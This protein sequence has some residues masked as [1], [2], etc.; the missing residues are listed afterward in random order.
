MGELCERGL[1]ALLLVYGLVVR[2]QLE[3]PLL[4]W[5]QFFDSQLGAIQLG[6]ALLGQLHAVIVQCERF[7]Q[8][9]VAGFE[10][11]HG[12][13]VFFKKLLE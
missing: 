9:K 8:R 6:I 10:F 7:V 3:F 5:Y 12:R 2:F 13:F 4:G 1:V 11:L